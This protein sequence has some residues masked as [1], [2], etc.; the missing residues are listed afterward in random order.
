MAPSVTDPTPAPR[1]DADLITLLA[2]DLRAAGYTVTG[3]AERLGPMA[4]AALHRDHLVPALAGTKDSRGADD[5]LGVLIRTFVLG[6]PVSGAD[7]AGALPRLGT[8]GAESLGLVRPGHG[9]HEYEPAIDL[10]PYADDAHDWVVASDLS[11]TVIRRALPVDHVLGIGGASTTLASWT[12]RRRV[13]RAL[14]LGTGCGVQA[15]HL[16]GHADRI[17]ATDISERAV[18]YAQLNGSLAGLELDLRKGNMLE[19]V[20]GER[21]D[22]I[23]SNP[24]FVITPRSAGVPLY[25]Y[26]DG[27]RSGDE[28][29]SGLVRAVGAHLEPGG[30]AQFLGNWEVPAGRAWTDVWQEWLADSPLDAW[31]IQRESQDPAEYAELWAR[32]GGALPGSA[33]HDAMYAAWL[34][35]FSARGVASVGFGVITLQRPL[36]DRAPWRDLVDHRG[37]VATPMGPTVDAGLA[38]RTWLAEHTDAD[39]LAV[40]WSVA[41]DVTEERHYRP[42]APDP[43]VILLRQGGG[44]GRTV[45]CSTALAAF[46]GVADGEL[47]AGV[48]ISA[49]AGLLEVDETELRAELVPQLRDLIADCL[50]L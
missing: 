6:R 31:I 13:A 21:F 25:E 29:V 33:E 20:A 11:E 36:T 42:G 38:A 14:D 34:A 5:P 24:P 28:I 23:V 2:A 49:I 26:R 40:P 4:S 9:D 43:A 48:A 10:R 50:L 19:P 17:V 27:G 1:G 22:L 7:L 39:L 47:P 46:V 18:A 30:I 44:L 37:A 12:P 35:D 45:R 15:L 8:A 16:S 3:V 32:D 41:S